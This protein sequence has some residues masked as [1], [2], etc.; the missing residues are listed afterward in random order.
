[1]KCFPIFKKGPRSN[2]LR[3]PS[4]AIVLFVLIHFAGI[5]LLAQDIEPGAF[6]RAPVGANF[7]LFTYAYQTGDIL[8]DSSLPLKDVSVKLNAGSVAYGRTFGLFGR[9]TNI[10]AA[11]PYIKGTAQGL[12]FENFTKVN[13]SGLG[14]MRLRFSMNLRGSPALEPKEFAAFKR[15]TVVGASLLIIAP[16]GQYDPS[17]LVNI[18]SNRWSFKPEVGVSKP[19]GRWTIEGSAGVWLYTTNNNFFGGKKREQKPLAS[20]QGDV[21][22]TFRPRLWVAIGGTYYRGGRT[23]VDGVTN[24]DLQ[25]NSRYGG[26]FS[27]P[28]G[29][30]HALKV[31]LSK[32][33]TARFG[34]KLSTIAIG[35]QYTWF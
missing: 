14:D 24:A 10:A 11:I 12:V 29:A 26:A 18:G 33:L 31:S 19:I 1:M 4:I 22:Y 17:K 7:V 13:R 28:F 15:K 8:L 9:Q 32:G 3:I 6:G 2:V 27:Y 20:L 25:S 16:T 23:T 21:M 35:W 30:H 5:G 34:G